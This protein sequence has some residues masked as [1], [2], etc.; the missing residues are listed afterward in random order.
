MKIRSN[1]DYAPRRIEE[2]FDANG[3]KYV[4]FSEKSFSWDYIEKPSI[5]SYLKPI[6][7]NNIKALDLGVGGGRMIHYLSNN[8]V[9]LKNITGVDISEKMIELA[10][11]SYPQVRF[12][13]SDISCSDL[14]SYSFDIITGHMVLHYLDLENLKST[15]YDCQRML[16]V[17]GTLCLTGIHPLRKKKEGLSRYFD[18]GWGISIMPWGV[19]SPFFHHTIGDLVQSLC[20]AKLTINMFDEPEITLDAKREDPTQYELYKCDGPKRFLLGSQK[21]G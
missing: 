13:Q 10:K 1:V 8:G 6:L 9:K 20:K 2:Y 12:I 4:E 14:P 7:H 3:A 5:D 15:L 19:E 16:K 17:G 21:W 11:V 18:R